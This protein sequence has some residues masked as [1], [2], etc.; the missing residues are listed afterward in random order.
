[1]LLVRY[2]DARSAVA[3]HLAAN[4]TKAT[5]LL[6]AVLSLQKKSDNSS[7]EYKQQ[8]HKLCLDA[9]EAF[10]AAEAEMVPGQVRFVVPDVP[11][12]KLKIAGVNISV[13][14]DLL[15]EKTTKDDKKLVGGAVLVFSKTGGPEKNI[16]SRCQA[17]AL[18]T[19]ELLKQ[20]L[21]S[22]QTIDPTLCM[23]IDVFNAK[24][25]RAKAQQKKLFKMV[26]TSCEE[27]ADRWP[28]IKPP[29]NYNGPPILKTQVA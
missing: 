9:I 15:T 16:E 22:H 18:L 24:I 8:N 5:I 10:Q 13:F 19:H 12:K 20:E 27:V 7:S 4:G 25:Y 3:A 6:D 2:D 29:A 23:A 11:Y 14:I 17:I 26:E 1:M 28:T 21:S